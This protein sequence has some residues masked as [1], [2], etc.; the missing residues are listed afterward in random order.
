ME[1]PRVLHR[2][3]PFAVDRRRHDGQFCE[4]LE[5]IVGIAGQYRDD[6][7]VA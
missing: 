5:M 4:R 1:H 6:G 2:R 3:L 7:K